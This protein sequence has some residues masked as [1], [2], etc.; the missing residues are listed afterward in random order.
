MSISN[1][2]YRTASISDERVPTVFTQLLEGSLAPK[3]ESPA[4]TAGYVKVAN[5]QVQCPMAG[6]CIAK[7]ACHSCTHAQGIKVASGEQYVSCGYRAPAPHP[8]RIDMGSLIKLTSCRP[9]AADE[10][11]DSYAKELQYACERFGVS[12]TQQQ[13]DKFVAMASG[14]KMKGR[15]LEKAAA[16]FARSLR[17]DVTPQQTSRTVI[18]D[19][20]AANVHAVFL[21]ASAEES[22]TKGPG[23]LIGSVRNPNSIWNPDAIVSASQT[24]GSDEITREAKEQLKLQRELEKTAR[25]EE[26]IRRLAQPELIKG[27]KVHSVSTTEQGSHN[28]PLASNAMS[29]FGGNREFESIPE[30]TAGEKLAAEAEERRTKKAESK[31]EWNQV[32]PA[33][34][35][36]TL[37]WLF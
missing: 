12:P 23:R 16:A 34:R 3:T 31:E 24:K 20:V 30:K 8:E 5:G 10:M 36:N 7:E 27:E 33:S 2:T 13:S 37:N 1:H 4:A 35:A 17:H 11:S 14:G 22:E 28:T 15:E 26:I 19:G 29:I 6:Q 32:K 9:V 21:G 18:A 25:E